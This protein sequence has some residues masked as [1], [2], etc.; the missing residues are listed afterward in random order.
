MTGQT[1]PGKP[2]PAQVEQE[3]ARAGA[4]GERGPAGA[5]GER[6][7][8]GHLGRHLARRR[9]E[10]GLTRRETAA[11][12]GMAPSYLAYLEERP[13]AAPAAGVLGRLAAVLHT[14]VPELTGGAAD[15]PPGAGPATRTPR[16]TE[17]TEAECRALLGTRGVG[18]VALET[19]SGP[20]I[21]PVN[22]SV[23][24]GDIVF[25]T[26]HGTTTFRASGR[27]VAFEADR[28]DDAFGEGWSVLVRGR[29][30]AVTDPDEAGRLAERAQG[31]PW[32]GGRRE[33]WVRIEPL[34]VTGRRIAA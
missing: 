1:A 11:L 17:L 12:A 2:G 29:A 16:F 5:P 7:P 13:L 15:L 4:A 31:V 30:R 20:V 14:T 24:D 18:R 33:E 6:G 22:Y 28:I 23:V 8:L 25:R 21:V 3:R 9:A 32:A 27:R 10:L 34:A 26:A 19:G